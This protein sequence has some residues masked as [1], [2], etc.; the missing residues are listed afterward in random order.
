MSDQVRLREE[1]EGAS[2]IPGGV[3]ALGFAGSSG[4]DSQSS[5]SE[6]ATVCPY[7]IFLGE[8]KSVHQLL[9]SPHFARTP[10]RWLR[11]ALFFSV[12]LPTIFSFAFL[13]CLCVNSQ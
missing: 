6:W 12:G 7:A 11:V 4:P 1:T 9:C 13:L 10:F 8:N 5:S 2:L 3:L